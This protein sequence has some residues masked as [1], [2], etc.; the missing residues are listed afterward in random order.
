MIMTDT[1]GQ[2]LT[3][4]SVELPES[5]DSAV[6]TVRV[7]CVTGMSLAADD[8]P[9]VR[10]LGREAGSGD[11]FQDLSASPIDLTPYAGTDQDFEVKLHAN[12]VSSGV[13]TKAVGVRATYNP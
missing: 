8:D 4:V 5:S 1:A 10:V 12:V 13:L 11:P 6:L 7:P 3:Y 2:E 9:D